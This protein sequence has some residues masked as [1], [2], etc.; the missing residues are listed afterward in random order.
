MQSPAESLYVTHNWLVLPA[1][2]MA[3][4]FLSKSNGAVAGLM[5]SRVVVWL[6]KISYCIYSL[7]ILIILPLVH[8]HHQ[9][10][11]VWPALADNRVLLLVSLTLLI[12][13][14]AAAHHLIEDPARSLRGRRVLS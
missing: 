8:S 13:A 3:I 2:A 12:A 9:I 11:R 7:Q 14:S 5:G 6:G 1:V 4:Y 10:V